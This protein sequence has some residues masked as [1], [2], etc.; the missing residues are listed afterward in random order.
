LRWQASLIK[1]ISVALG[2]LVVHPW[3]ASMAGAQKPDAWRDPSNHQ[4]KFIT[5]D[6]DVQLEVLDW[7]G[8]GRAVVLLTGSGNTAH[9]FD[10]FAPK[11]SDCCHVYGVTRRGFGRSSH[12]PTGYDD[13]RLA[14]DVLRVIEALQLDHPV[15]VGH[16]MGGGELTTIGRQHSE[17]ISGLVYLA[18]T[19]DPAGDP[20][21]NDPEFVATE[22]KLPDALR[23]PPS[24]ALDSSSFG[25]FQAS[26]RR[27]NR[28]L[29][30]FPESELRQ[31]FAELPDG[32]VGAYKASTNDI[33]TAIGRGQIG[34][35]YSNI[36][37]PVLVF[38]DYP[39]PPGAP[40][41]PSIVIVDGVEYKPAND[42]ERAAI[43]AYARVERRRVDARTANLKRSVPS[44][45][46]VEQPGAGHYLFL[47][48]EAEVLSEMHKFLLTL[49]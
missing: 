16:S 5:V 28:D 39:W 26:L 8:S 32:R 37:V 27:A 34:R 24:P 12:P 40:D 1:R 30:R 11:L 6:E 19:A 18:A 46:V 20:S 7:G 14:D 21:R 23:K 45:R 43:L 9:V 47:T 10:D 42:D 49:K 35:D 36:R 13:Q 25:A 29:G 4:V 33:S 22:G 31:S 3:L 15:L 17:R 48:R 2:V 44:A 41:R 38:I